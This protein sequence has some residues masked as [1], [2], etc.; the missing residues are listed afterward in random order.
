[1]LRRARPQSLCSLR[2]VEAQVCKIQRKMAPHFSSVGKLYEAVARSRDR[3]LPIE[4][5]AFAVRRSDQ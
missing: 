4:R 5:I 3:F 2:Q 1:M